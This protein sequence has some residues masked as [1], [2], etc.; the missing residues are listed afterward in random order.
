MLV[1]GVIC[2]VQLLL[3]SETVHMCSQ[4]HCWVTV[5]YDDGLGQPVK[6]GRTRVGL[7]R[8]NTY[9][10]STDMSTICLLYLVS[11]TP[12]RYSQ[13]QRFCISFLIHSMAGHL[14]CGLGSS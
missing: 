13:P 5:R 11:G 2:F 8:V 6:E 1:M 9:P 10:Q 3:S 4:V 12:L 14:L 7:D